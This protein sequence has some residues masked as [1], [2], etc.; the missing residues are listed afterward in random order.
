MSELNLETDRKN[1]RCWDYWLKV[2]LQQAKVKAK[3]LLLQ[4]DNNIVI[5][6]KEKQICLEM[7]TE[8]NFKAES[9]SF[10]F[11]ANTYRVQNV[12]KQTINVWIKKE[13]IKFIVIPLIKGIS[14][15][16]SH[17]FCV[18]SIGDTIL[19]VAHLLRLVSVCFIIFDMS[20][21]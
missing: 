17:T 7:D 12:Y 2:H 14:K 15:T 11:A 20:L 4:K 18:F 10:S 6:A 9:P 16:F 5:Q 13:I 3:A 19:C 1:L 21:N 8:P